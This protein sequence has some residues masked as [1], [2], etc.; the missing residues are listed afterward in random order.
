MP[1][2]AAPVHLRL[3]GASDERAKRLAL[4]AAL[5]AARLLGVATGTHLRQLRGLA[6]PMTA[7]Q[8]RLQHAE[9]RARLA[10]EAAELLAARFSKIPERHRPYFTPAQRFRILEIRS[11]LAWSA[12]ETARAFLVCPHTILNWETAADPGSRTA[13]SIVEP[14]PPV[15]RAADVVRSTA[16]LLARLGFGGQDL[17]A[18]VLA[19][20]GWR[21]SARSIGRY[22]RERPQPPA[23]APAAAPHPRPVR[24]RFVHHVWMMDLSE[25]KQFLGP[26]LHIAA[27]FDAFSRAPLAVQVFELRPT[28]QDTARLLRAAARRLA[29]PRYLVSDLGGEFTAHIFRKAAARLGV[30]Q[31]F[32]SADSLKATA[33]LERFW[34]TLKQAAGLYGL[35]RPFTAAALE[36]RLETFLLHYLCFRPHEGLAGAVPAE[37]LFGREPLHLSSVEPPRGLPGC[38]PIEPPFEVSHLDPDDRRFPILTIAA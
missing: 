20:A 18:R 27:V 28:A 33:R 25:V 19:R 6:D 15:R 22:R 16:Q 21:V 36:A 5:A 29:H 2:I 30:I 35:H 3:P 32:A 4:R 23:P 14:T 8:A 7:L 12:A 37:V 31:R 11:L 9:L 17:C 34:L 38:G 13:G 24:S 26:T 10:S 1:E